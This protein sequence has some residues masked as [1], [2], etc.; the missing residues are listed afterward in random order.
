[1]GG[2]CFAGGSS[3]DGIVVDV[4]PLDGVTVEDG[5]ATIG[6]GARLGA[7]YDTLDAHGR[8]IPA[9]CGP[10][11]GIAGLALGGGLGILGRAHGL[12]SDALTG[13]DVVLADGSVVSTDAERDADLFWAL[14]GAG[15]GGFGIV[16]ALRF[17]TLAAPAATRLRAAWPAAAAADV[18]GAWQARSPDAPDAMAASLLV[19]APADPD[20]PPVVIVAGAFTGPEA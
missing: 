4:G 15:A 5:V 18:L 20:A 14:R 8:T 3:T 2:H 1:G 17:R 11:V 19:S 13:A 9:G 7:V 6:A 10:R 12:T 16:I